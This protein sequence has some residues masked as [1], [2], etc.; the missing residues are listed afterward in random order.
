MTGR[1][2]QWT[3]AES[4]A[5]GQLRASLA[6]TIDVGSLVEGCV[7][8]DELGRLYLAEEDIGIWRYNPE[9]DADIARVAVDGLFPMGHL[10][11]DVEGL[12]IAR[13]PGGGGHLV[14]SSQGDDAYL[15]YGRGGANTFERAVRVT[16]TTDGLIDGTTETDG[17]EVS[18]AN[19]GPAFPSGVFVAQDGTNQTPTGT[20]NQ[21]FK[22][23][24]LQLLLD[25]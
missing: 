20:A 11:D 25:P 4:A 17:I 3:V 2:Q 10:D 23:V 9:P 15:V 13:Q 18:T 1:V 14:A 16:A 5:S 22:L 12:A 24:P 19:L 7:A 8:D 6:R 21:N